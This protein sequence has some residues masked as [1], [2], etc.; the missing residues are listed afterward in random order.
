[1]TND[2]PASERPK[3]EAAKKVRGRPPW[4]NGRILGERDV[5]KTCVF[6]LAAEDQWLGVAFCRGM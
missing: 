3:R 6:G 4:E 2:A 5:L 1:M